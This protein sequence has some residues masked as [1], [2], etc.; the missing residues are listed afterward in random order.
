M[1]VPIL[2]V[3]TLTLLAACGTTP[4]NRYYTLSVEPAATSAAPPPRTGRI[5]I[6]KLLLPGVTDREQMV[7]AT[8]PQTVDIRE[9]DRWAEPLDQL[10]PRILAQDLALR[11]GGPT[12]NLPERRLFVSVDRFSVDAMGSSQLTGRWWMLEPGETAAQRRERP[13]ALSRPA[14]AR[15]GVQV[16][17]AMSALLSMLA[18]DVARE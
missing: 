6:A 15:D 14:G 18:D 12:S 11:A 17:A 13:F 4:E 2:I 16:A 3:G 8:G 9:F 5:T 10:V 1:R 7:V